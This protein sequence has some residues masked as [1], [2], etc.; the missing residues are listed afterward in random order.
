MMGDAVVTKEDQERLRAAF[1]RLRTL[2]KEGIAACV[3][4]RE[5]FVAL[6]DFA[7]KYEAKGCPPLANTIEMERHVLM[8]LETFEGVGLLA[9]AAVE[10]TKEPD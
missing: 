4:M 2:S 1:R 7:K 10:L 8:I 9:D 3:G 6:E 5:C